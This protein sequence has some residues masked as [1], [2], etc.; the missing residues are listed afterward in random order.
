[1]CTVVCRFSADAAIPVQMLALRDELLSRD[2]DSPDAWWADQPGVV[3]GRDRRAGGSWCVSDIASG[4]TAV[5]LN[6][7]ERRIAEAGAPS[8]GVLPLLAV[9]HQQNWPAAVDVMGMA[10]FNLVLASA[11]SLVWWTFDG[12][13]LERQELGRGTYMFTPRGI[14]TAG[15]D[16]RL[17][18]GR[19]RFD[20]D[21]AFP[22]EQVWAEWLAPLNEAEP[23]EDPDGLLVRRQ[24]DEGSY[25]TVFGQFIAARPG[26]LRLDY[27]AHPHVR[28]GWLTKQWTVA[29]DVGHKPV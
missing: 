19:V 18:T 1:V 7:P 14:K 9:G 23:G 22:T 16:E 24:V 11:Q 21:Q 13:R 10:S 12:E 26:S 2:F 4:V 27:L 8:R 29:M 3:G 17:A 20:A 6:R 15:F 28:H 25:E 5:V